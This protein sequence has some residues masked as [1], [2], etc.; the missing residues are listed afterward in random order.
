MHACSTCA[1]ALRKATY[2][3]RTYHVRIRSS[4]LHRPENAVSGESFRFRR[5]GNVSANVS[6]SVNVSANT[7]KLA[8]GDVIH[9]HLVPD[10]YPRSIRLAFANAVC[11]QD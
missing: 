3:P 6:A 11:E 10:P 2:V 1:G 5:R 7:W 4:N 8:A 9:K